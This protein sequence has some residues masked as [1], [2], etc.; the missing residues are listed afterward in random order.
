MT[1][2]GPRIG[3]FDSGVGGLTVAAEIIRRMPSAR[4]FYV[5]DQA[6]VPYGGRSLDEVRRFACAISAY[7]ASH[8]CDAIVMACNISTAT[9]LDDASRALPHLPVVG[10]IGPGVCQ[11]LDQLD[12]VGGNLVGVLATQ[13][14][15]TSGAYVSAIHRI[16]PHIRVEQSACPRFVPLVE[17]GMT[18]S[19]EAV[20]AAHEALRPLAEA[21]CR[22][23]ILGCTHY[24]FMA[25][26]LQQAAADL[27]FADMVLVDPARAVPAALAGHG[28][29]ADGTPTSERHV[30]ITTGCVEAFAEQLPVFLPGARVSVRGA[31]WLGDGVRLHLTDHAGSG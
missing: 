31:A 7:L 30:M 11:A 24:P 8:R 10:V 19:S 28:I 12:A 9:A 26:A 25:N 27:G 17:S 29:A 20:E 21:G 16:A 2:N 18:G 23:V 22:T 15:V 1:G 3:V 14:T 6:H 13:G 4:I 5:A